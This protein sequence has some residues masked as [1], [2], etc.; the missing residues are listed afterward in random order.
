MFL[1]LFEICDVPTALVK[2]IV[3]TPKIPAGGGKFLEFTVFLTVCCCNLHSK[4]IK[5]LVFKQ[6]SHKEY[7]IFSGAI[8]PEM[9]DQIIIMCMIPQNWSPAARNLPTL[10][11]VRSTPYVVIIALMSVNMD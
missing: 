6:K 8:A 10:L 3:G 4:C 11:W 9:T 7:S 5:L 2:K 1:L